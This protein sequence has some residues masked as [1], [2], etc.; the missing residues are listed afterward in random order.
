M[1]PEGELP[2]LQLIPFQYA[3]TQKLYIGKDN[4]KRNKNT[5]NVR[6]TR[7]YTLERNKAISY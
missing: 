3:E 4:Q 1:I 2:A 5:G 6:S 7:I